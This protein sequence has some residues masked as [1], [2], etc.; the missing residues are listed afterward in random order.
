[1]ILTIGRITRVAGRPDPFHQD[2]YKVAG[3][4]CVVCILGF[5]F[6]PASKEQF[7]SGAALLLIGFITGKFTNGF[8][9]ERPNSRKGDE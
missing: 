7:L 3:V 6:A 8:N 9:R 4:L 1:V 5:I 2:Q